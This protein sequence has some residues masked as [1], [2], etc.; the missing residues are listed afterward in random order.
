M[1]LITLPLPWITIRI[2]IFPASRRRVPKIVA[3]SSPSILKTSLEAR[4]SAHLLK[5][6]GAD[7]GRCD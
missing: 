1:N 2:D 6:I 4:L 5:D 3:T 7:E